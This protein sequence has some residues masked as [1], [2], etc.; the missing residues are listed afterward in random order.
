[1]DTNNITPIT[2]KNKH[3][4]AFERGQIEL[5]QKD[6]LSPYAI[7][8]KIGRSPNT[9]RNELKRGTV[10]QIRGIYEKHIYFPETGE[11]VYMKNRKMCGKKFRI[12]ECSDF[13][14]YVEKKFTQEHHSLDS[15]VGAALVEGI[16]K[17]DEMV[18]TKTLYN[19]VSLG[20]LSNIRNMDLPLKL[21]RSTKKSRTKQNKRK[22]GTSI[23]ERPKEINERKEFGHWE[24]DT[25]IGKKSKLDSV[26]LTLTERL[27]RKEIIIKINSKQESSILESM[28]KLISSFGDMSSKVFRSITSDNG[29]EFSSLSKLEEQQIK[30]YFTHPYSAYE[31]GTNEKHNGLIRRFIPK[32]KSINDYS[33]DTIARIEEWMNTL[34]RKIFGYR[35]PD[36]IFNRQI[37][38]ILSA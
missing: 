9:I 5:L 8:K 26:L 13:I 27:S 29:T 14:E 28:Q 30:I 33:I 24:I 19:Y 3:L 31:R 12:L 35:T 18:C 38:K 34:P 16:F 23:V 25:V 15:I 2:R 21:R 10:V 22:L 7:A 20:L 37:D 17:K 4:N 32:G 6:G 36:Y 11:A 1:M